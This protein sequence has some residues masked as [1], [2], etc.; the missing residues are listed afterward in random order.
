MALTATS[1]NEE[2]RTRAA[3]VLGRLHV[4]IVTCRLK[5]G[6]PLRFEPL[7]EAYGASFTT[8]REALT[9]LAA[10][11]LVISEG[12]RGFHVAPVSHSDL[13]DLTEA[14]V[15]IERKLTELAIARGGDEWEVAA[16]AALHR[17]TLAEHRLGARYALEPEWKL[18]HLQ[19][20]EAL[21]A[22][23]ASP[24]LL[25]IRASLFARAERYRSLSSLYRRTKRDKAGEHKAILDAALARK[26]DKALDLID[27]HI[28][29][30]TEAVLECGRKF[31]GDEKAA[32]R[33]SE[34]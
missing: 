11:G 26:T 28:R 25:G 2:A 34:T 15:L 19:F 31:L 5:P 27:G 16:A 10:E 21:V 1:P 12:Q 3:D 6:E 32:S 8:L 13:L 14:R 33:R 24:I 20:H 9:A 18:L 4:D 29:S 22:A 23:S 17:M 30:T 7:K